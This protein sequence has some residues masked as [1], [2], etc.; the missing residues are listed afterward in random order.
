METAYRSK[1]YDRLLEIKFMLDTGVLPDPAALNMK[2]GECH[3]LI[4]EVEHFSIKISKEISVMQQALNNAE[5]VYEEKKDHL[6][7]TETIKALP[8]LRDREAAANMLLRTDIALVSKYKN[9]VT[10]LNN[11]LRS[12]NLKM[13]NLNRANVDIKMQ[14]RVFEA[15]A[16]IGGVGPST[17]YATQSLM[18]EMRKSAGGIDS[19]EA[20]T[21][22]LTES[23]IIDPSSSL[24]VLDF[25]EGKEEDLPSEEEMAEK[26]ID[27]VPD[28]SPDTDD[29]PTEY[30]EDGWPEIDPE[31]VLE[32]EK[33]LEEDE[34]SNSFDLD[35]VIDTSETINKEITPDK[36]AEQIVIVK[37]KPVVTEEKVKIEAIIPGS[38]D[39]DDILNLVDENE[40]KSE[41][42]KEKTSLGDVL[43]ATETDNS[44]TDKP[45]EKE[46]ITQKGGDEQT[47]KKATVEVT[48]D[49]KERHTVET[50][51]DLDDLLDS[52]Q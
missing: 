9:D 13:K 12:I 38:F 37:E 46:A 45:I 19:F 16:K 21:S 1:I 7:C 31:T 52:F 28:L 18:E 17:N 25:L 51:M 27:P 36:P 4:S 30:F 3:A 24:N 20:A 43:A 50:G 15:Q 44:K 11:L 29:D 39:M 41:V 8:S 23:G 26:L 34:E 14:L 35:E 32:T 33:S 49:K 42:K 48:E 22:E 40:P 5:V 6:F 2:I 47:Q 10:D